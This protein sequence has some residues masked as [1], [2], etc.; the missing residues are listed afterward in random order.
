[1]NANQPI[2]PLIQSFFID[3]LVTVKG[4]RPASVRSYRDTIRLL[5]GFVAQDNHS[6]IT[7]L[8]VGD[9]TF[10]RVVG[11]LRYLQDER[12]NHVHTRNQRLAAVHTLFDYIAARE[13]E[14]LAECQRVRA[15]PMKRSAPARTHYLERDETEA[16]FRALPHHG[17]RALRDRTLL[18]FLY[19]T[20]ARV[21]ETA[22]VRLGDLDLS[23]PGLVRLHGKGDKWRT[24]PLWQQT[25]DL[26]S[27]LLELHERPRDSDAPVFVSTTGTALTRSGIYKIVR[28]HAG[29]LDDPR[30]GRR[31]SP[32]TFRHTAAVHLLEAG[33]EVNV[34]RGWLG[35][36]DLST[37]NRYAEINTNA[38]IQALRHTEPSVSSGGHRPRAVWRDDAALLAWLA[39][40]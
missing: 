34:I 3:H 21:Q 23:E 31:I 28:R 24:C 30:T 13:P 29:H 35:H 2:G 14:M 8:T 40:L 39:S 7:K 22:D 19:N 15:I 5:L 38:K 10:E 9:M 33:V 17:T 11:F 32:H 12:G 27:Q 37:T 16:L 26:L 4:L 36:A 6:R 20:A 25:A 1:M 18:L